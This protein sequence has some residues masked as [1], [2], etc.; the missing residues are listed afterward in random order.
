MLSKFKSDAN[1]S[2]VR[3]RRIYWG[4]ALGRAD[5]AN[6]PGGEWRQQRIHRGRTG[7][8][9]SRSRSRSGAGTDS[10]TR[11]SR[12]VARRRWRTPARPSE[13]V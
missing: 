9:L 8:S 10:V 5:S 6:W 7:R 13:S 2:A 4:V 11:S 3:L 1:P 12:G